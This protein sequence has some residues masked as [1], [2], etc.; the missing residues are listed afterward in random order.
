MSFV[1]SFSRYAFT[2]L[3]C[4]LCQFVRAVPL[5]WSH[6]GEH[7]RLFA[8]CRCI[9]CWHNLTSS[10]TLSSAVVSPVQLV[11]IGHPREYHADL[12]SHSIHSPPMTCLCPHFS[13]AS[14][15][16]TLLRYHSGLLLISDV[17]SESV[18]GIQ[19]DI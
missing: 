3:N 15:A 11:G 2:H 1:L 14:L 19:L 17:D 13:T 18:F 7:S 8:A 9:L 6:A 10:Y 12:P 5:H 4:H 16:G